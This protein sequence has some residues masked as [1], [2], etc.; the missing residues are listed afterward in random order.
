MIQT[1]PIHIFSPDRVKQTVGE[2]RVQSFN[3]KDR[4]KRAFKFLGIFW[5]AGLAAAFIPLL[6]FV[7][8]PLLLIIGLVASLTA[9][10][11]TSVILGGGG[12][13]PECGAN[14]PIARMANKPPLTDLCTQCRR[15]VILELPA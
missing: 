13:C 2:V 8:V 6:H 4:L 3:S 14:L 1:I 5:G 7:L 10:S 9:Y 15:N 11:A 12:P